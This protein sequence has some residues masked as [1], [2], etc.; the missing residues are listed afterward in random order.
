MD[1]GLFSCVQQVDGRRCSGGLVEAGGRLRCTGCGHEYV[2]ETGVPIFRDTPVDILHTESDYSLRNRARELAE[3]IYGPDREVVKQWIQSAGVT[4][5]TLEIGC[6]NG[7]LAP[8]L[9]SFVGLEYSLPAL[10]DPGWAG[11]TRV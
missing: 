1:L 2:V 3:G 9:P 7:L 10:F 6:G 4:G 8:V 11:E 5:P